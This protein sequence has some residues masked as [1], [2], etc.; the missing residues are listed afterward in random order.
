MLITKE[1]K[2]ADVILHDHHIIPV[3]NRFG[4]HLG[5]GDQSIEEICTSHGLNVGFFITIVNTF[6]DK[7]FFPKRHLLSFPA[8]M[9]VEYLRKTHLYY[10]DDKIPEVERLIR[11]MT[12]RAEGNAEP[13]RL[14]RNFFT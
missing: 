13:Y 3:I 8:S 11:E 6:H 12:D 10:I 14:A 1:M 4:I 5:F 9:L 2:L 7:Q